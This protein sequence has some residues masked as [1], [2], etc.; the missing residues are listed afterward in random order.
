MR[1]KKQNKH[2]CESHK[3]SD[4]DNVD[5]DNRFSRS[6]CCNQCYVKIMEVAQNLA[7]P[8]FPVI[9]CYQ[10]SVTLMTTYLN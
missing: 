6:N 9:S 4:L 3:I 5:F 1:E 7:Q 2:F 8:P 10:E